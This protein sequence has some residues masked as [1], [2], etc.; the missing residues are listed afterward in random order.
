MACVKACSFAKP[1]LCSCSRVM[2]APIGWDRVLPQ[3]V[4]TSTADLSETYLERS[5]AVTGSVGFFPRATRRASMSAGDAPGSETLRIAS[6]IARGV[7][8]S[9][10]MAF[11]AA[12]GLPAAFIFSN[13]FLFTSF[14]TSGK[15]SRISAVFFACTSSVC[16]AACSS[17]CCWRSSAT[18]ETACLRA[19]VLLFGVPAILAAAGVTPCSEAVRGL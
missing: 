16:V 7:P 9:Q 17:A 5:A 4:T 1:R 3:A 6:C 15:R 13:I 18:P 12:K 19:E 10:M 8:G 11:S 14:A 2:S